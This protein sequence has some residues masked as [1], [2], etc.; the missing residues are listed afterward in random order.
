[1]VANNGLNRR[2]FLKAAGATVAL[3]LLESV[4]VPAWGADVQAPR[5]MVAILACLG[6]C[7]DFLWPK[8]AGR[9]YE[10][11]PYLEVLQEHRHSFTLFSG[12]SHPDV[13]TGHHAETAFLS[14]A[15]NPGRPNFKNSVS[16]D[17]Y[18]LEKLQP[19]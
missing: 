7:P 4:G 18:A 8:K 9:D 17:Q 16:L 11:T 19:D 5:R 10:L 1:M 12:L 3:P 15:R 2:G 6:L 14:G 13:L